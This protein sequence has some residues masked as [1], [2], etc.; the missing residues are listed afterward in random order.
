V[1]RWRRRP[2]LLVCLLCLLTQAR[3]VVHG[4]ITAFFRRKGVPTMSVRELFEFVTSLTLADD[5][6]DAYLEAVRGTAVRGRS[7]GLT[8]GRTC[9]GTQKQT[10]AA[11]RPYDDAAEQVV[12]GGRRG[13]GSTRRATVAR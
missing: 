2:Y 10:E 7:H 5:D 1:H 12:V 11:A 13:Q 8:H 6:V 3:E 9:A 4:L